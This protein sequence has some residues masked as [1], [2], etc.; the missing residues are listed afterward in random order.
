MVTKK[1]DYKRER[2]TE[3]KKR[4]EDRKA[5][6][7]ARTIMENKGLVRKGD[8]KDVDHRKKL[9]S[10]GTNAKKNLRVRSRSKNSADNAGKGGRKK[11]RVTRNKSR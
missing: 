1:R 4:K 11:K 7:R 10:G 8:G 9:S 3:S 5:R 2:L 6:G